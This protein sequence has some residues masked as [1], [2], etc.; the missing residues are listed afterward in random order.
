MRIGFFNCRGLSGK[1]RMILDFMWEK[2]LDLF[3]IIETWLRP[4]QLPPIRGNISFSLTQPYTR[5]QRS[6]G[7]ILCITN[8][9]TKD[10]I[11]TV[12]ED[13]DRNFMILS[14]QETY[15]AVGYFPPSA[16][17]QSLTSFLD[18]A[19]ASAVNKD[20]VIL[21]DFNARLGSL[22]GDHSS[23]RR[24][25]ILT[26]YLNANLL[27][28]A[29]PT[30]G[31]YTTFNSEGQGITDIVLSNGPPIQDLTVYEQESLGGSDHR[32]LCFNIELSDALPD[33][34]FSRWNV[35]KLSRL[36]DLE[37]YSNLLKD[38]RPSLLEKLTHLYSEDSTY[39]DPED[40][41]EQAWS[42][43]KQW[44][45][46][47]LEYSIG[48]TLYNNSSNPIFWTSELIRKKEEIMRKTADL[49]N[50]LNSC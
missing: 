17:H 5:G 49:Q 41:V 40:R 6:K 20:L 44:I 31:K 42:A 32:P 15:L 1:D 35:R 37:R 23:N 28:A 3:F 33:K 16:S 4:G 48:R 24:G 45:E 11:H 8:A 21:G 34:H 9:E 7:G 14:V 22:T 29:R 43:F 26:N 39:T 50:L 30:S 12:H 13:P 25:T 38:T 46:N 2:K 10:M 36:C 27:F 18:Q 19:V 47:A